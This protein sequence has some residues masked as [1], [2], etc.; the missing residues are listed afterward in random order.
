[1]KKLLFLLLLPLTS[2]LPS[3]GQNYQL[4]SVYI[5]S[6]IK[7]VQWP[8]TSD[9][10]FIIG[11]YG[12]SPITDHLKKMAAVKKAGDKTIIVKN[13]NN[14]SNTANLSILFVSKAVSGELDSI[15]RKMMG[16]STL[17]ITEVEGAAAKG[18]NINFVIRSGKLA[19]EL[20]R[21]AMDRD[22]LKVSS[23]LTRLAIII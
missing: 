14:L 17:L 18:S 16:S 10:E 22:N 5:Y 12:N 8:N 13:I 7:Y 4:H 1:M 9:S 19:F 20:N 3:F 21:S 6:F 23:E 2:I 11:V 15:I